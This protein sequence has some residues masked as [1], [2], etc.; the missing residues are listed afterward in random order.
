[1]GKHCNIILLDEQNVIIDSLRHINNENGSRSIVPHVK[2]VYPTTSKYNFLDCLT[3]EDFYKKL[4]S[5]EI[6]D[7]F[8]GISKSFITSSI[9]YLDINTIDYDNLKK[10][11]EYI[12]NIINSTDNNSLDFTTIDSEKKDYALIKNNSKNDDPFHLNF[13]LDDFYYEKESRRRI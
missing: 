12:K 2:Y 4:S 6:S 9:K 13:F 11:Y 3:F 7:V 1:M 5:K 8:N 10:L